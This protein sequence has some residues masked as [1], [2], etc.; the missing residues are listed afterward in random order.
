MVSV[1]A[2]LEKRK[3]QRVRKVLKIL[4]SCHAKDAFNDNYYVYQST[5]YDVD[6]IGSKN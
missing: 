2:F 5:P 3:M 1:A 4:D 6:S